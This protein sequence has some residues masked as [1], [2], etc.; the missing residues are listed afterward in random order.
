MNE[1]LKCLIE[2][3][4]DYNYVKYFLSMTKNK[5]VT[6][7]KNVYVYDVEKTIYKLSS[8]YEVKKMVMDE[9]TN[10]INKIIKDNKDKD[11]KTLIKI[12][13][14]IGDKNQLNDIIDLLKTTTIDENFFNKINNNV[15]VL[16][17]KNGSISLIDGTFKKRKSIDYVLSYIDYDYNIDID[18]KIKNKIIDEIL[19]PIFNNSKGLLKNMLEILGYMLTG[20]CNEKILIV[21]TGY[22]ASNGK[23]TFLNMINSALTNN[24]SFKINSKFF[25]EN[26]TTR[27]KI[28]SN[29]SNKVFT[30]IEEMSQK[31][32]E[33]DYLK[34]FIDGGIINNQ[35]M[36]STTE[37]IKLSSTLFIA[38]N[39]LINY[40]N[41]EGI[42]R[43]LKLIT[44]KNKFVDDENEI[45]NETIFLKNKFLD[46]FIDSI[47]FKQQM[48]N[49]MIEYAIKY[50]KNKKIT[51]V[52]E[53][54]NDTKEASE[55]NDNFQNFLNEKKY[56]ITKKSSDIIHKDE[57]IEDYNDYSNLKI[58]TVKFI[59]SD[60]KRLG[61]D[62]EKNK[63]VN[64]KQGF[65]IGIKK[66]G[67]N[68]KNEIKDDNKDE[69]LKRIKQLEDE[70]KTLKAIKK[71]ETDE[72]ETDE[73]NEKKEDEEDEIDE[74]DI[75]NLSEAVNFMFN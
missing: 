34:S 55:I 53:I 16:H 18:K 51:Y 47:E 74:T 42:R 57:L 8:E 11:N 48:I 38:T 59:I 17:F 45:N 41:D 1:E 46:G 22:S 72:D 5:I 24:Y 29:L 75:N 50:N 71:D 20:L 65:F 69:L 7:N 3:I 60:I 44:L 13:K 68:K 4:S 54:T 28:I 37:V 56:I 30:Y 70:L 32:I 10:S 27:H 63:M 15:N 6:C 43:R 52:E 23:T 14:N 61:I 66:E 12:K 58:K 33:I 31:K 25:D 21:L 67:T 35:K 36:Y 40:K 26:F 73:K 39:H 62:Y 64:K 2:D 19:M 9:I 49:I